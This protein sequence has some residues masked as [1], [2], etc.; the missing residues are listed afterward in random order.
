MRRQSLQG[1]TCRGPRCGDRNQA[2]DASRTARSN[3]FRTK[4]NG[5]DHRS[6]TGRR[7]DRRARR[8]AGDA[9]VAAQG[10]P[11]R[12]F[13][14][15]RHAYRPHRPLYRA[16]GRQP[17][18][19]LRRAV[20]RLRLPLAVH[21]A[22][23]RDHDLG[24]QSQAREEEAEVVDEARAAQRPG[25]DEP[26]RRP[27]ARLPPAQGRGRQHDAVEHP[28]RHGVQPDGGHPRRRQPRDDQALGVHPAYLRTHARTDRPLLR[29]QRDR[30]DDRRARGGCRLRLAAF[31]PPAVHRRDLDR[32]HGDAR[33]GREPDPGH[34]RA[35]RQSRR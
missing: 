3:I 32:S 28:G 30:R 9:G 7:R 33:R 13:R 16:A 1:C 21:H 20:G 6:R 12:G 2:S 15:I 24:G 18:S 29:P 14:A 35:G 8:D 31:R 5:H 23:G 19:D 4:E 34:A 27:R 26:V 25:A 17:G 22:H 10:V 11:G